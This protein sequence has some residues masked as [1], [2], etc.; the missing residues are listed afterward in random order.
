MLSEILEN[1]EKRPFGH[2]GRNNPERAAH[3]EAT[4]ASQHIVV[5]AELHCEHFFANII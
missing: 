5:V 4:V 2:E 1:A 3:V